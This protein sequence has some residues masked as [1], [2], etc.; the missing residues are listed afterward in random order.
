[1]SGS[2]I[3]PVF[4]IGPRITAQILGL[5][6]QQ[7]RPNGSYMP[8]NFG[9]LVATIPAWITADAKGM[10]NKP[11]VAKN[12][13]AYAMV[14]PVVVAVG[15]YLVGDFG[16]FFISSLDGLMPTQV[17]RCNQTVTVSR[18][19][20]EPS[21]ENFY[22][23]AEGATSTPILVE[24]PASVIQGTKG[25]VGEVKLPGDTRLAWVAIMLPP[26]GDAQILPG[27]WISTD[28]STAMVYTVS[29][30]ELTP[31]GWRLSASTA[32]V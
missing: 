25:E 12:P 30:C 1:M 23:G 2:Q 26:T 8:L 6:Y 9:N 27:D 10:G 18:P 20:T 3:A 21:G 17:V 15:D 4:Q 28:Q 14:D 31:L 29:A 16:T 11:F 22:G 5:P 13:V 7:Y 32:V 19:N 24:W